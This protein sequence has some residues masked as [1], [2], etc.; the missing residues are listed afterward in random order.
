MGKHLINIFTHVFLAKKEW[1]IME[2][3]GEATQ[4]INIQHCFN[5]KNRILIHPQSE[6]RLRNKF[7]INM[8]HL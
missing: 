6:V 5:L 8:W 4:E 2:I 3:W 1:Y 7:H